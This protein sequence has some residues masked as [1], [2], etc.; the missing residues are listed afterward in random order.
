MQN[1]RGEWTIRLKEELKTQGKAIFVTLTYQDENLRF[2]EN[3]VASVWK[4]DVQKFVKRLRHKT[5]F[6]YYAVSEY[7]G[8]TLRPHYHLI[9]FGLSQMDS[10][11]IMNAWKRGNIHVGNVKE[12]GLNYVAKYHISKNYFPQGGNKPFVL[13]STRPAIGAGYIDRMKK[14]HENDINRIHYPDHE[15]KRKLPRYYREKLYSKK[16]LA[17]ANK[18]AEDEA[19]EEI[20]KAVE[21]AMDKGQNYYENEMYQVRNRANLFKLKKNQKEKL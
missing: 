6:R 1:R 5:N 14:Y 7:G 12:S 19:N 2:N 11:I 13:M 20:R 18:I 21:K 3:N 10:D 8:I 15:N 17:L 4:E 9:M 16:E